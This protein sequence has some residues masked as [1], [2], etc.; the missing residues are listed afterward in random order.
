MKRIQKSIVIIFLFI[1]S[2][3]YH[4]WAINTNNDIFENLKNNYILFTK[5]IELKYNFDIELKVLNTLTPKIDA[6]LLKKDFSNEKKELLN[7]LLKINQERIQEL[8]KI[9]NE[10]NILFK[11]QKVEELK[12]IL[13]LKN[14]IKH[15]EISIFIKSIQETG[16]NIISVDRNFEFIENNVI[17]NIFLEENFEKKRIYYEITASNYMYFYE[18]DWLIVYLSEQDKYI[19]LIKDTYLILEKTP[20]SSFYKDISPVNN[21][22]VDIEKNFSS[23]ENKNNYFLKKEGDSYYLI[24][25]KEY[26]YIKDSYWFYPYKMGKL[27]Y[28]DIIFFKDAQN[29]NIFYTPQYEKTKIIDAELISEVKDKQSFI[30]T[31]HNDKV[32]FFNDF[33]FYLKEIKEETKNIVKDIKTD[34]EKIAKIYSWIIDNLDY[35][36]KY[37]LSDKNIFSWIM[38]YKNRSG[39][40]EWYVNLISY[41]LLYAGIENVEIISWFVINSDFFPEIWH[42][43]IRIWDFYYD[44]TFDDPVILWWNILTEKKKRPYKYFKLPKELLYSDRYEYENLPENMKIMSSD[45]R[46]KIVKGNLYNL[47]IKYWDKD[48]LL[49][50]P[51]YFR[52]KYNLNFEQKIIKETLKNI[53]PYYEVN[54]SDFTTTINGKM[55]YIQQV[56]YIKIKNDDDDLEPILESKN[57]NMD[58]IYLLKWYLWPNQYEYRLGYNL[59]MKD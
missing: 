30:E 32:F 28:K 54:G 52:I 22:I 15:W 25:F 56:E 9:I 53:I 43:W 27:W 1:Y 36:K 10:R 40:C 7:Y 20:F 8:Q 47:A 16:K 48:F 14:I 41:M 46:K 37:S 4:C 3:H 18:L 58:W 51:Y 59:K 38:T 21:Y 19:F 42:S 57:F 5:K 2:F 34:E 11:K 24:S 17:K 35:P 31:M 26:F 29:G 33:N 23:D 44:P 45:E 55:E 13:R 39:V 50:K 6:F 12:Y 49:L